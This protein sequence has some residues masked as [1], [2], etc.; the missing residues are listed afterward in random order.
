MEILLTYGQSI[1]F[2]KL[3]NSGLFFFIFVFSIQLTV[4]VQYNFCQLMD[5]N[6]RPQ[7]SEA[8]A[9]VTEPQLLANRQSLC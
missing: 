8:T 6:F 4:N 1:Y 5:S 7:E 9:L 3:A 2:F